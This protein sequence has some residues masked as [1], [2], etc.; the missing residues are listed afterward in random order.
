MKLNRCPVLILHK[1]Y[2]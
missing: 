2:A 1:L